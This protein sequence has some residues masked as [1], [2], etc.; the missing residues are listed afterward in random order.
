M[1]RN[2]SHSVETQYFSNPILLCSLYC[3][4]LWTEDSSWQFSYS[5]DSHVEWIPLISSMLAPENSKSTRMNP[6]VYVLKNGTIIQECWITWTYF[7]VILQI[8]MHIITIQNP[9]CKW[10]KKEASQRVLRQACMLTI[11]WNSVTD[12][13]KTIISCT[14]NIIHSDQV[15]RLKSHKIQQSSF[16]I[17]LS[18]HYFIMLR[19]HIVWRYCNG[20][21]S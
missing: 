2:Q 21:L 5:Y 10:K 19:Y 12:A 7:R 4:T 17:I 9:I 3:R 1:Y 11:N 13:T 18:I 15:A 16:I 14:S 8:D 20:R 6:C